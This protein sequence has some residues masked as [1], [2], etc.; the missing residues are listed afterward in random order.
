MK[1]QQPAPAEAQTAQQ[2]IRVESQPAQL[3]TEPQAA[4]A[5]N[6]PAAFAQRQ[7]QTLMHNS[8]QATQ[9]SALQAMMNNSPQAQHMQAIQSM[10]NNAASHVLQQKQG[11]VRPTFQMKAG[12]QTQLMP[13]AGG[14]KVV[15]AVADGKAVSLPLL[16]YVAENETKLKQWDEGEFYAKDLSSEAKD[17]RHAH[18][19]S[20]VKEDGKVTLDG[21]VVTAKGP[22]SDLVGNTAEAKAAKAK[23]ALRNQTH[24]K[25]EGL[26]GAGGIWEAKATVGARHDDL[27]QGRNNDAGAIKKADHDAYATGV[28]DE[29]LHAFKS[30]MNMPDDKVAPGNANAVEMQKALVAKRDAELKKAAEERA[31]NETEIDYGAFGSWGVDGGTAAS[32]APDN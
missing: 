20:L 17:E 30:M 11:R 27:P 18:A 32:A 28:R 9:A 13:Q 22:K 1:T 16:G 14:S 12:M 2:A 25:F 7:L 5:D 15:Q 4:F 6:R 10:A 26:K 8:P 19:Y 21:H 24:H 3:S 29:L 31:A 23:E